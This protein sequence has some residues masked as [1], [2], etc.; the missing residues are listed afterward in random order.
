MKIILLLFMWVVICT[1][2]FSQATLKGKLIDSAAKMPLGL[3]TVTVFKASD[4]AIITYRL[5][6]PE[7]DFK[8]P[9]LPFDVKCRVVVSYSGY[10][11]YRKEFTF[12]SDQPVL[13]LGTVYMSPA[14]V[15]MQ[16]VVVY[17]ER[18]PVVIK[19][20]TVEFNASAFKTLPNALVEDLL[21]KLPGVQVDKDGN[22]MVNGKPVNKILVD[23]KTFFGDDP[24]MASRNLPSQVI[25]KVQVTDDKEEMLRN[26]DDNANNVGKVI[27]LTLKKG[28]KKSM[29]GKAYAGGGGGPQGGRYEMGAIANI[30]RD[31]LQVSVM[32]Y[33][34]NLNRPGF[35]VTDMRQTMGISRSIETMG[36][37]S[38]NNNNTSNFGSSFSINDINFGGESRNGGVTKSDGVGININHSPNNKQSIYG[39]YF[40]GRVHTDVQ[41]ENRT[42]IYKEDTVINNFSKQYYTEIG[43]SHVFGAGANL[44]PDSTINLI[45]GLNYV[46]SGTKSEKN[47][48]RSGVNNFLGNLNNGI[49]NNIGDLKTNMYSHNIM[50]TKLS[51]SKKGRRLNITQNMGWSKRDRDD[52]TNALISYQQPVGKDTVYHQLRNEWVPTWTANLAGNY[53]E[54]LIK[55]FF[56]RLGARYDYEKMDDKVGTFAN[57]TSAPI[58]DLSSRFSRESN[59]YSV[60]GGIEYRYKDFTF[61]P[62]IRYQSQRFDNNISSLN[63]SIKQEQHNVLPQFDFVYKK[64]SLSYNRDVVLPYYSNLIPVLNNSNPYM[65]RLGNPNLQPALQ[66]RVRITLNT[67]SPKSTLG[68]WS[69]FEASQSKNVIVDSI[70]LDQSGI[71]TIYPVNANG[72]KRVATNFGLYQNKRNSKNFMIPWNFGTWTEYVRNYFY[73]NGVRSLQNRLNCNFWSSIGFNWDDKLELNQEYSFSYRFVKNSNAGFEDIKTCSQTIGTEVIVRYIKHV[74]F[75]TRLRLITNNMFDDPTLKKIYLWNAAVNFT[76]FKDERAVLR[77]SANDILNQ[78]KNVYISPN[79]NTAFFSKGDV[80]AQYFLSTFTYNLR[81]AG[82]KKT[83]A[84]G[85][86]SL[87]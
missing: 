28:I 8:V 68:V 38:N 62:G 18:P 30:F 59:K 33:S 49:V 87:F 24:K 26:G 86:W 47:D 5:S 9:G 58:K 1:T 13:D 74:I 12:R 14:S 76:F 16:E 37:N 56:F 31:T 41:N 78:G 52:Y 77:I 67:Y 48:A 79:Q 57:N 29:F 15:A 44:K 64:L 82:A 6:N 73:Y 69:W 10:I 65:T 4:T 84:G 81:P 27:N 43:N 63:Q 75:D 11:G 60:S 54:P 20:D 36:G 40:Y 71:Q 80:L 34:N 70:A 61:R 42:D 83:A 35:S 53:S 72:Y 21:K 39:Q 66:D 51:R 45:I 85:K 7:G 25:D 32:G 2:S 23:G 22:I 3:A 50:F 55:N 19:K 17:A 46:I